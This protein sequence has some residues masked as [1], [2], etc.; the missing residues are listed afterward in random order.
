MLFRSAD[1]QTKP[2]QNF[3]PAPRDMLKASLETAVLARLKTPY[4]PTEAMEFQVLFWSLNARREFRCYRVAV[5]W[6]K[7]AADAKVEGVNPLRGLSLYGHAGLL[8]EIASGQY[9]SLEHL[10]K[11]D[12]LKLAIERSCE[13][14]RM[15]AKEVA[16]ISQF[17]V[18]ACSEAQYV[19]NPNIIMVS[20]TCDTCILDR[21]TGFRWL[22][23]D[24]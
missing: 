20:D 2:L 19:V 17:I 15:T 7:S 13:C 24:S 5:H 23:D 11:D 18:K 21:T 14:E 9:P 6:N 1:K 16:G 8:D 10:R 3:I 12:R 4:P 22:A